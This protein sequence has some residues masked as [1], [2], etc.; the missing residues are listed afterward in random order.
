MEARALAMD[1][2]TTTDAQGQMVSKLPP[3]TPIT[4]PPIPGPGLPTPRPG[5]IQPPTPTPFPGTGI[6]SAVTDPRFV[7]PSF[8]GVPN[9]FNQGIADPRFQQ[10]FQIASQFPTTAT[11]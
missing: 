3:G 11:T 5:P 8:P 10:F 4:I 2:Q 6:I 7:G 9:Y 1:R